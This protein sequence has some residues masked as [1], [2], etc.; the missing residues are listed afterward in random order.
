[1]EKHQNDDNLESKVCPQANPA[2]QVDPY[3]FAKR[4]WGNAYYDPKTRDFKKT[5]L[6]LEQPRSFVEFIL[7]PLYKIY[8]HIVAHDIPTLK[9][10]MKELRIPLK[11]NDYKLDTK[12]LIIKVMRAWLHRTNVAGFVDMCVHNIPSPVENAKNRVTKFF[13]R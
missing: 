12:V 9:E 11:Q 6:Y 13:R 2:Y 4:L 8:S 7:E 1:M 5:S 10:M 3:E